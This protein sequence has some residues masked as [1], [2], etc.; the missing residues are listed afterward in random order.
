MLNSSEMK[1]R[2]F[3]V[4]QPDRDESI[5]SKLFDIFITALILGSVAS[6]F[7]ST[8]ELPPV[9]RS[10]LSFFDAIVSIIFTVEYALRIWTADCLYP[11]RSSV[12]ARCRYVV[13]AMAIVD[14][15]AILP[16]WLPMIL[17]S[18]MLGLRALRLVRLLR[19]LKLNRYFDALKSV[20]EVLRDKR[21]ELFGS[22]FFILLL[23]M[24]SSLL[25]YSAEHD[26]QPEV[27]RNAF[28][29]LW[30]A[31]ATLT[32]VGYG[33]IYPITVLGRI[34]GAIIAFSGIAAVAIPTG[35]FSAGLS[36]RIQNGKGKKSDSGIKCDEC[37]QLMLELTEAWRNTSH[38]AEQPTSKIKPM[39]SDSMEMSTTE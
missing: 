21:R 39:V 35:I 9:F 2:V 18:T 20:L 28:S 3:E 23:M 37:H 4:I 24:V 29:G 22:I 13:S 38:K 31:V 5:P 7:I 14:L 10:A 27:F 8:F 12:G 25:M 6:V 19:I 17:P 15:L 26:A 30:W 33:D 32:T 16:F 11:E 1:R 34:F 36:E